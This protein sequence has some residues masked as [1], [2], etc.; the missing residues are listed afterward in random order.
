[1]KRLL[2]ALLLLAPSLA[3]AQKPPVN[4]VAG[5]TTSTQL[6]S[7][8]TDA[9]GS[10]PLNFGGSAAASYAPAPSGGDDATVLQ[11][12]LDALPTNGVG[13]L[14][15]GTYNLCSAHLALPTTGKRIALIGTGSTTIRILTG[16]VSPPNEVLYQDDETGGGAAVYI[17]GII[18]DGRCLS[19]QVINLYAGHSV[20]FNDGRI[21]N[22][23]GGAGNG[24]NVRIGNAGAVSR[25]YEHVI[26][27]GVRIDNGNGSGVTCYTVLSDYPQYNVEVLARG[28][29]NTFERFSAANAAVANIYD[30]SGGGNVYIGTHPFN[31]V[32]GDPAF[33]QA[34]NFYISGQAKLNGVYADTAYTGIFLTGATGGQQVIGGSYFYGLTDAIPSTAAG[35]VIDSGVPGVVVTG[36]Q[37]S[38][39]SPSRVVMQ[40]G[41]A[42]VS[43]IVAN[44]PRAQY[45]AP[46]AAAIPSNAGVYLSLNGT[47]N[48]SGNAT[49]S[50]STASGSYTILTTAINSALVRG[51][52]SIGNA[53]ITDGTA[54]IDISGNT[55]YLSAP[56]TGTIAGAT[57]VTFVSTLQVCPV[58]QGGSLFVTTPVSIGNGCVYI[59]PT[60]LSVS[61]NYYIY[62]GLTNTAV[63]GAADNGVSTGPLAH[64]V[65]LTVASTTGLQNASFITVSGVGGTTEA[66]RS[67]Y[68]VAVVD[69]THLDLYGSTFASAYTSGGE[70]SAITLSASTTT[71]SQLS[72][73]QAAGIQVKSDDST[74]TLVGFARVNTGPLWTDQTATPYRK[75]I[76]SWYNPVTRVCEIALGSTTT[77]TGSTSY[78]QLGS[79]SCSLLMWGTQF[80]PPGPPRG[81]FNW[82]FS[83][84]ASN[85][86]NA[87]QCTTGLGVD[88]L[89]TAESGTSTGTSPVANQ[90]FPVAGS[91]FRQTGPTE[92][93]HT[94]TLNGKSPSNTCSWD[95]STSWHVQFPG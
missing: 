34:Y 47:P 90:L 17:S 6:K 19:N 3:W 79:S 71:H 56:T 22:A 52:V 74:K 5:P 76:I 35:V 95:A 36:F 38:Q 53:N 85:D 15:T 23:K 13:Y 41:T 2:L 43:T 82:S 87:A 75:W 39:L 49:T 46:G 11:A 16:C 60:G 12:W 8:I 4:G 65:R 68:R 61:S 89:T 57:A 33:L 31:Y 84:A 58:S 83:G 51:A 73:G 67:S 32:G 70:V 88:S 55:L 25:S 54:I 20:V 9:T 37:G 44:N 66:N 29:D 69:G 77:P 28:T 40:S 27:S 14:Q 64:A 92:G 72:T 1:M 30:V 42:D 26:R 59:P 63:S 62:A 45:S 18:W 86:T 80:T 50:G 94:F 93:L 91:G 81:Q 10:G 24:S 48:G 21:S 78:Q 7:I